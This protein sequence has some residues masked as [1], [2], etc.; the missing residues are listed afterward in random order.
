MLWAHFHEVFAFLIGKKKKNTS[1]SFQ[2]QVNSL[3]QVVNF[4]VGTI[5]NCTKIHYFSSTLSGHFPIHLICPV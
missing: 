2:S 4:F 1:L 5:T 3:I